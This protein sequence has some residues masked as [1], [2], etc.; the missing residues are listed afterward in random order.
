MITYKNNVLQL[1]SGGRDSFLSTCRLLENNNIV[2]LITYDNGCSLS[3]ENVKHSVDRLINRYGEEQVKFLGVYD[4][5]GIWR[6]FFLSYFNLRSSEI[7]NEYG[8]I[9]YSQLN[10]LTCRSSMYI[11]S[12][13]IC[14][15]LS[16]VKVADGARY[17][18]GFGIEREP[19]LNR[20]KGLFKKYN[21]EI[22]LPVVDLDSDWKRKNELMMYGYTPKVYE[23]QCLL[24]VPIENEGLSEDVISGLITFYDTEILPKCDSLINKVARIIE[25]NIELM[26]QYQK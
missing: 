24:G 3:S 22:I 25:S 15:Y 2:H 23:P 5:F 11:Y 9:T 17:S 14:K 7:I 1:F 26:I 12:I 13:A 21:I 20:F 8:E 6:E 19:M 4:I 18:Q 16:I 10:C